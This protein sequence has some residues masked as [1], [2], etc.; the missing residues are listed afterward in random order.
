MH[1]QPDTLAQLFHGRGVEQAAQLRLPD[2]NDAEHVFLARVD[3]G[4]H[5]H[6]LERRAR[7]A[8]CLVNGDQDALAGCLRPLHAGAQPLDQFHLV[9]G[10]GGAAQA[11]QDRLEQFHGPK[12]GLLDVNQPD[13]FGQ[14]PDEV[15][16]EQRLARS[17][18]AGDDNESFLVQDRV[19]EV[20]LCPRVHTAHVQ[21]VQVR[22]QTERIVRQAEMLQIHACIPFRSRGS[23][24]RPSDGATVSSAPLLPP[25]RR[26]RRSP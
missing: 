13:R 5:A 4:K 21:I 20:R 18:V 15:T 6:F 9:L 24:A 2:Q 8:L 1:A 17:H 19:L 26:S 11:D 10:I 23:R 12:L 22:A 7:K 16:Q 25:V 3:S 14:F